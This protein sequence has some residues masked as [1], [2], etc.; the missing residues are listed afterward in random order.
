MDAQQCTAQLTVQ[1]G[2]NRK[3]KAN[4]AGSILM[5]RSDP[6][7]TSQGRRAVRTEICSLDL[8]GLVT[9]L[10]DVQIVKTSNPNFPLTGAIQ[11]RSTKRDFAADAFLDCFLVLRTSQGI[12]FQESVL[13]VTGAVQ[14]LPFAGTYRTAKGTNVNL[15]LAANES[16]ST[17]GRIT[18][19]S[20]TL[21]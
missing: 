16:V 15:L 7:V 2:S 18:G 21:G 9:G 5:R 3:Q 20:L 10:G 1:I 13:R 4:F 6:F 12:M 11:A 17:V 8:R 14:S 19:F